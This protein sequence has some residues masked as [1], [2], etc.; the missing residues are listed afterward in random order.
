MKTHGVR[1][2]NHA[3]CSRATYVSIPGKS[4][5]LISPSLR[6]PTILSGWGFWWFLL[7]SL[8]AERALKCMGSQLLVEWILFHWNT[9]GFRQRL[10]QVKACVAIVVWRSAVNDLRRSVWIIPLCCWRVWVQRPCF[11]LKPWL[12]KIHDSLLCS[13]RGI[14]VISCTDGVQ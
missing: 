6:S 10:L 7:T 14:S 9:G 3:F 5:W 4:H 11:L 12:R 2:I 13:W 8:G 1:I